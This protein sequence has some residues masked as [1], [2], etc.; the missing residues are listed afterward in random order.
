MSHVL[1]FFDDVN[2]LMFCIPNLRVD[3][4]F[5]RNL[6]IQVPGVTVDTQQSVLVVSGD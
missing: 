1:C 2:I 4:D 6:H 3:M 5:L